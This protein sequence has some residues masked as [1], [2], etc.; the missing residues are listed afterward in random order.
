MRHFALTLFLLFAMSVPAWAQQISIVLGKSSLPINQYYKISVR[1][2]D[3]QLKEY[4]PFPEIEGFKKSNKY[5]ETQTIITGGKTT[6]ILTVT[7]NYA[8]LDEG[9]FELKPFSMKVNGQTVQSQGADIKIL[10]MTNGGTPGADTPDLIAQQEESELAKGPMEFV[11]EDDNAFLTLSTSKNEVFVGEG[12]GIALYFYL[13]NE[14]QRLLDFY[15][16]QNQIAGIIRQLKQQNVWEEAFEMPEIIPEN[17]TIEQ[18]PYLRFKLY[19]SVLYPIN[20]EDIRFP[21]L[22]LRMIKYK[23]AKNP[24]LLT[25]DRQEGFKTFYARERVIKVKELPPH[26][27][28]DIVPV[29]SYTLKESLPKKRVK[30]NRSFTYLFQIE[31]EGNLSAIMYPNPTPPP[32]LEL[33][34]PDLRQDV[35]RRSGHVRGAK[36]FVYTALAREPG[37]YNLNEVLEW[38]YFDPERATY[39]TLRATGIITVTGESD[40]DALILSRDLGSFYNI[41]EN[42]DASLVSLHTFDEIRRYTNIILAILLAVS[43]VVF[44]RNKKA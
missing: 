29:G 28:R 6:T 19:E 17:V 11:D 42:E 3:Q 39:D 10:P 31:G 5:S 24:N 40:T 16:F 23:V 37:E 20:T 27:L 7:Q 41:I 4:S 44:I 2:Q 32:M 12:V 13:A 9:T 26:P 1:L 21:Q 22:S 43:T 30:V 38:V 15:D 36:S 14:D 8:A 33:Y 25:E 18:K 34:P 35:T